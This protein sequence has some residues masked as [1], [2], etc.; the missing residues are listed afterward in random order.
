[1]SLSEGGGLPL[2]FVHTLLEQSQKFNTLQ[3]ALLL[4]V[5]GR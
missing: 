1:M 4:K 5:E 2:R 3:A